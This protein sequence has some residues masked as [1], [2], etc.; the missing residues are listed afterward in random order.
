[1]KTHMHVITVVASRR[2]IALRVDNSPHILVRR[3]CS[4]FT[5]SEQN[6]EQLRRLGIS[7]I[8]FAVKNAN[9]KNVLKGYP[10][11]S[12]S[13]PK[14]VSMIVKKSHLPKEKM[15]VMNLA[16]DDG[17]LA[18]DATIYIMYLCFEQ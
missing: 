5:E 4:N 1:M 14:Y 11:M 16:A 10:F 6:G 17:S 7:R 8:H 13:S 15:L 3:R 2:T 12:F 18:R 9:G